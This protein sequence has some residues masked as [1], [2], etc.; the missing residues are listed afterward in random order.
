MTAEIKQHVTLKGSKEGLIFRLE[1]N[2]EFDELLT[3]LRH[4]LE[5]SHVQILSGPIVHVYMKL[6]KRTITEDQEE[7]IRDILRAKGNLLIQSIESDGLEDLSNQQ[8]LT[9]IKGIVRSGQI[10]E[11]KGDLLFLGD[12]NPGGSIICTGSIYI[13]G[14][15]RGLA[16][17]GCDGDKTAIIAASYMRPTQLRIAGI[18]S[19]SPDEWGIEEAHMEFAYIQDD[20]MQINKLN[21]LHQILP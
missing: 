1:D 15:L 17:A 6:G 14:A 18:V 21:H 10:L 20:V 3:S 13:L 8:K 12:V 4:M 2:C 5:Q 11:H 9:S 19:R 16:H 7:Q